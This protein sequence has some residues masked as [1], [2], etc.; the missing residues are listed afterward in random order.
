ML[1]LYSFI[2]NGHNT[3]A[4]REQTPETPAR[5]ISRATL[6]MLVV[7]TVVLSLAIFSQTSLNLSFITPDG[8]SGTLVLIGM[9]ALIFLLFVT[10]MFVL[11]R[12]LLKLF[13]ERRLGVLG[14][15]F[16]TRMVVGGLILSFLPVFFMFLFAYVLMN[17]SIDKWFSRPVEELKEDSAQVAGLLSNYAAAN[18]H[19]EAVTLSG[20]RTMQRA[21]AP[22]H[23]PQ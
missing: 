10:L 17:H 2:Y 4:E 23:F 13:A 6:A 11:L 16:R 18:A 5:T 20:G 8:P 19:A 22:A 1:R 12:N 21:R 15:A 3:V 7:G 9:S 14:S